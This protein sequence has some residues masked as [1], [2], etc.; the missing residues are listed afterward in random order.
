MSLN[1]ELGRTA[2][3]FI[4][5]KSDTDTGDGNDSKSIEN[6]GS[7]VQSLTGDEF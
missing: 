2:K 3:M 6:S 5:Q 4:A 1:A 7:V